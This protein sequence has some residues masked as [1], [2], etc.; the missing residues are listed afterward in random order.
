MGSG[1]TAADLSVQL[2]LTKATISSTSTSCRV[3]GWRHQPVLVKSQGSRP[4]RS[5]QCSEGIW[6]DMRG[7]QWWQP[8]PT[9]PSGALGQGVQS[10][11]LSLGTELWEEVGRLRSMRRTLLTR[12][13]KSALPL[14][15]V[16][17]LVAGLLLSLKMDKDKGGGSRGIF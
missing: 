7:Q 6:Q 1:A 15:R 9:W 11:L 4:T 17:V 5:W 12:A 3:Q 2:S 13:L 10:E 16:N 8:S 14:S